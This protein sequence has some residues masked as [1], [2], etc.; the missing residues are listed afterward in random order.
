MA[1]R[2]GPGEEE[3]LA[4]LLALAPAGDRARLAGLAA[5]RPMMSARGTQLVREAHRAHVRF[6]ADD[7]RTK[8]LALKSARQPLR[9]ARLDTEFSRAQVP[10]PEQNPDVTV[11][12]GRVTEAGKPKA[13]VTVSAR[14]AKGE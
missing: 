10:T 4:D 1:N 9:M 7:P 6:G 11:I 13:G 14:G 8:A 3:A 2:S 5:A 12:W